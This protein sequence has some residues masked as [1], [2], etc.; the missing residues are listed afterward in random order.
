MRGRRVEIV[1]LDRSRYGEH[2]LNNQSC[3][4]KLVQLQKIKNLLNLTSKSKTLQ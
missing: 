4:K 1:R 2:I 3:I